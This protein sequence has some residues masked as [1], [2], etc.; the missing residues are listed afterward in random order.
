ME[1]NQHIGMTSIEIGALWSAYFSETTT[2]CMIIH[3]LE[4]VEDPDIESL[5]M[6]ALNICNKR[7]PKIEELLAKEN[8]PI[9]QGFTDKDVYSKT[10]RLFSDPFMLYYIWFM[11]SMELQ[12]HSL[13]MALCARSDVNNF[14]REVLNDSADTDTKA[15]ELALKKGYFI[16][17]PYIPAPS[18]I[19][20]VKKKSFLTGWFGERRP[21]HALEITHLFK[22]AMTNT[23]G[24][25][26]ITGFSQVTKSKEIRNLFVR[27]K[28]IAAKHTNIFTSILKEE[29]LSSFEAWAAY[30]TDSTTPPFSEKLM[31][32]QIASLNSVGIGNYGLSI[33]A[34]SRRD[35]GTHYTRL[36]GEVALFTEDAANLMIENGWM[37][38]PP[39]A[40][41]RDQLAR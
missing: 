18:K 31:L 6:N 4:T 14:Y 26:L 20:F 5:L 30:V 21:L 41:N 36:I 13:S 37:E 27:G 23:I 10:P 19:D 2:K 16:R 34:S 25:T 9:P 40:A 29:D 39:Q 15:R 8:F 12:A 24:Y 35:L 22:N 11:S 38:Q 33:S 28:Q 7:I 32:F 3:F 1:N 17:A